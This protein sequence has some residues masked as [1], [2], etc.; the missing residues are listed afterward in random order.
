MRT[1]L[2]SS[3]EVIHYFANQIQSEGKNQ[4][5]NIYFQDKSL[6]SYGSH[7]KLAQ[8]LTPESV[9]IND[10]GYSATT[11]KHIHETKH[12]TRHLK[13]FFSSDVFL[14]N[15]LSQCE[16]LAKKIPFARTNKLNHINTIKRLYNNVIEFDAFCK[17]NKIDFVRWSNY[18]KVTTKLDKRSK[19]FKRLEYL[20]N[21]LANI[22]TLESEIK[23]QKIREKAKREREQKQLIKNYRLGKSDFLRLD[24]DLLQLRYNDKGYYVHTSQNVRIHIQEAKKLLKALESLKYNQEAINNTLKGYKISHYTIKGAKEKSLVVGCHRIKF[25][26]IKTIAKEIK[27][28]N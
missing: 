22:E 19:D 18:E 14:K 13:R 8:I 21:S 2:K 10:I 15:A 26:E 7:Y 17:A 12:A 1:V 11:S 3:S 23:A 5:R 9:L 27:S 24:F 20:Y 28:I 4:S 25:D 6:F 16:S